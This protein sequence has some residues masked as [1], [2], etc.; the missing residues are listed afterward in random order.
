MRPAYAC[1]YWGVAALLAATLV[2]CQ[3]PSSGVPVHGRVS[4]Q[5]QPIESCGLMF[6]PEHG[7]T[8]ATSTDAA[9]EYHATLPPGDY[10]VTV[11]ISVKPPAGWKEGDPIPPPK[12]VLPD[13]YTNR[14]KSILKAGVKPDQTDAIDFDLKK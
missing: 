4:Y 9:G 8:V 11:N 14:V 12:F 6:Y 3:K 10:A 2:G 7:R 13:K 5:A 1:R